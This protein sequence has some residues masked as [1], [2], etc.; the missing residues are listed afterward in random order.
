MSRYLIHY[1]KNML[2]LDKHDY[3]P[4]SISN[5][6]GNIF[7]EFVI[8]I[9]ICLEDFFFFFFFLLE[10]LF[11]LSLLF[12]LNSMGIFLNILY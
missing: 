4:Q 1:E 3:H 6:V 7:I 2:A 11:S 5:F 12:F 10:K 9:G 8:K